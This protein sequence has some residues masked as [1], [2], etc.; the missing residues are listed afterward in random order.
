MLRV[1][2]MTCPIIPYQNR[3][4]NDPNLRHNFAGNGVAHRA[5]L[6]TVENPRLYPPARNIPYGNLET[7]PNRKRISQPSHSVTKKYFRTSRP[8]LYNHVRSIK[9]IQLYTCAQDA[10]VVACTS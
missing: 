2:A 7:S 1:K 8:I 3:E 5:G 4:D 6:S 10:F 9:N